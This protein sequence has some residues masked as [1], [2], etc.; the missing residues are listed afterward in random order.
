MYHISPSLLCADFLNMGRNIEEL[1]QLGVDWFH[2]DVMDGSFVPNFAIGTDAISAMKK[3]AKYPL[4][5]HLMAVHPENHVEPFAKLGVEYFCFHFET[6]QNPFRLCQQI[7]QCGMK[8]AVALNPVTPVG[9]LE[10]L[11]E[12]VDAVTLMS[13]EPGFSGQSF[14]PFMYEK[15]GE[16][17]SLIGS[18]PVMIEVDGGV[19]NEIAQKCMDAGCDVVVGGYF[20]LFQKQG[21]I[22]SNYAS[23]MND[24]RRVNK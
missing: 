8:P 23:F 5:A 6:T 16:L 14:L 11:I 17:K 13:I 9:M 12:Y 3:I 21:S 18:R 24:V 4:Y 19:N 7:R 15:I 10:N 22:T 2:L 20:T 1:N